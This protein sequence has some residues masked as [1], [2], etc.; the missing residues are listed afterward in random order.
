VN[1]LAFSSDGRLLA[2]GCGFVDRTSRGE[3]R[4]HDARTGRLLTVLPHGVSVCRVS[5]SPDSRFLLTASSDST[6]TACAAHLWDVATSKPV[7]PPMWHGDG[8]AEARF[9]PDGRRIVTAGEDA[10]LRIWEAGSGQPVGRIM[11]HRR[12]VRGAAFSPDSHLILSGSADGTARLWD[13]ETGMPVSPSLACAGFVRSVGFSPDGF[14]YAVGS[15]RWSDEGTARL[16]G[17]TMISSLRP[18]DWPVADLELLARVWSGF[19]L[20][21]VVGEL[22]LG[23]AEVVEAFRRLLSQHPEVCA[24]PPEAAAE[25]HR[26]EAEASAAEGNQVAQAFHERLAAR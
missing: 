8:L 19:R 20:D 2:T 26:Q 14:H 11:K 12:G 21:P 6:D 7:G 3:A 10:V 13:A 24:V 5:F 25:W 9:S 15:G 16:A 23:P 4:I 22:P 17:E 18:N 1:A